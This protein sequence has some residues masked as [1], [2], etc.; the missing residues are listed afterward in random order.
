MSM[1]ESQQLCSAILIGLSLLSLQMTALAQRDQWGYWNNGVTESWWFSA[2]E[3]TAE[4]AAD[5]VA[6]W[7]AIGADNGL[8]GA[9]VWAG[10]YFSGGDTHGT[11]V[12]WSQKSGYLMAHVDKCQ[13][14]VMGLSYG[15]VEVMPARIAFYPD[16]DKVIRKSH[17]SSHLHSRNPPTVIRYVP[18][19]WRS[20]LFLVDESEMSDFGDYLVGLGK[21]NGREGF[22][23]LEYER[24]LARATNKTKDNRVDEHLA[25]SDS[26]QP[27]VPIGDEHFLKKPVEAAVTSVGKTRVARSYSYETLD[28]AAITHE[29]VLLTFVSVNAGI[30]KGLKYGMFLR[31][32]NSATGDSVRIVR[33]GRS[34]STGVVIRDLPQEGEPTSEET[35]ERPPSKIKAGW[36]LTT[37]P[38]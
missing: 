10:D 5:A 22:L 12:R 32:V 25:V 7:N 28:G 16:L 36:Q 35:E 24:F 1:N 4:E 34:S 6:R 37:S 20:K 15:R 8:Q 13:A 21:F 11:Y 30:D 18:I 3:F 26:D 23:D 29:R 2:E 38:F 33:V 17:V 31:V 19:K 9:S 14:K 27:I